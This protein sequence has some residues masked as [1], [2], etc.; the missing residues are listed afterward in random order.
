[1]THYHCAKRIAKENYEQ[2]QAAVRSCL[3]SRT[4]HGILRDR[5]EVLFLFINYA[6]LWPQSPL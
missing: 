6:S 5:E 2:A 1:M 3:G 4:L